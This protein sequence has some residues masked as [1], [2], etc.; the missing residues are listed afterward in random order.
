[1]RKVILILTVIFI[2]SKITFG[3]IRQGGI[4]HSF[5]LKEKLY[6][7]SIDVDTYKPNHFKNTLKSTAS[8]N[9]DD[10]LVVEEPIIGE[11]FPISINPKEQGNWSKLE[12]GDSLWQLEINSLIGEYM[13]LIFDDFFLPKGSEFFVFSSDK[14]QVLGAFTSDNNTSNNKFSITPIKSQSIVV[15]YYHPSSCIEK[16][17]LNIQSVGIINESLENILPEA[18]GSSGDCMIN[19]KCPQY[20]N[21]CNQRRSVALIIRVLSNGGSIR[22]CSG[23][24]V[25]N[26]KRDGKPLFL[27]AFHCIDNDP[28][29][30]SIE[31]SEKD[32]INNWI[33]VFNYQSADC[34]N[35]SS[36]PSLQYSISGAT[37]INSNHNSDYALLQLNSRPPKD[38]N[39]YYNGWSNDKDDM[40]NWGV[41]IHH[42]AGDIKKISEWDKETSLKANFWKV[43]WTEGSTEGGSSGAPLF[44][45]SGYVVG[46]NYASNGKPACDDKKRNWFGRFD[47]S[48]HKYGL[49]WALNPNGTH[50]GSSQY[51][52]SSMSGDEPCK[53]NW[54][55]ASGDDLHTSANVNFTNL[56]TV[57]TRMSDGVYNAKNNI[58][59]E[60]VTIQSATLVT[61]EAG[62][63]IVL[64]PGFVAE[65]GSNFTAKIGDCERGCGN[66]LKS[67]SKGISSQE[68]EM[69]IST[70]PYVDDEA[71]PE[72]NEENPKQTEFY[73]FEEEIKVY[74]NPNDGNFYLD[75]PLK[76]E[77]VI[78]IQIIDNL[79]KTVFESSLSNGN[80]VNIPNPQ[81]GIYFVSVVMKD[82]IFTQ[83][84]II[85]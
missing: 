52:I 75:I 28:E 26:E 78:K 1:M 45:N 12:N 13:M 64:K 14:S 27:T 48:W 55:F 54:Y 21:W 46:Q 77:D 43:K 24:L 36:E 67:A 83:K 38:Y 11:L 50:S 72:I 6:I 69:I 18:L 76:R 63:S 80:E 53:E 25:T 51:Y 79:G 5:T 7:P 32:E 57:G 73:L 34:N 71:V 15:E 42:P 66:G 81:K 74:P 58:T 19:A 68:E 62:Q 41:C 31:Q 59:A 40:T 9:T 10:S 29:N 30:N 33:F 35:P 16:Y 82:K 44:N 2:S 23:S 65:A 70:T 49:S 60:N 20:E 61:F 8:N 17:R 85:Q 84:I 39:V 47:K 22:W 37:Y 4:P 56:S 3:Q